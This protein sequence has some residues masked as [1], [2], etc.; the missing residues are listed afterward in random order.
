MKK[1]RHS[2]TNGCNPARSCPQTE[3][4]LSQTILC[5]A[6]P[7]WATLAGGRQASSRFGGENAKLVRMV[8]E[9]EIATETLKEVNPTRRAHQIAQCPIFLSARYCAVFLEITAKT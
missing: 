3:R 7:L 9:R 8:A 2:E 4:S 5:V 6:K 1:N